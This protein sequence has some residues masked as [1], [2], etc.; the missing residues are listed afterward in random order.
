[1]PNNLIRVKQLD[2]N[3]LSGFVGQSIV[4]TGFLNDYFVSR[5]GDQT[6]SGIKT[7]TNNLQASGT[8]I[9][10][11][12]V[13]NNLQSSGSGIFNAL[14]A[15]N[16]Q[17]GSGIFNA[18]DLNNIDKLSISGVDIAISGR[19]GIGIDS[20]NF[21]LYVRK[22]SAGAVNPD[23]G[24]IAVFEGSGN[25]HITVLASDGQTAGVVLGSPAD[26]FG[27]YLS[28]NHDN[29]E[30]KLATANPDGYIQ[31]L[32]NTETQAV[33]I[34]SVGNVG[35]GMTS[36]S[37]K[38]EVFG[39]I[40]ASGA[41]FTKHLTVNNTGVLLTGQNIFVLQGGTTEGS[42][43]AADTNYIGLAGGDI[44]YSNT[45]VSRRVPILENCVAR[46]A[47]ITLQQAAA[48]ASTSS[49]TGSIVNLT[50]GLTG[51]IS[52]SM[53]TTNNSNFISFSNSDLN[54]PFSAGDN[55]AAFI[56]CPS[57]IANLR[58]LV[59]VYFYN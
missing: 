56:H 30:L 17:V 21:N 7:F 48:G 50:Q 38:L 25:S 11:A 54:V 14:V 24:S 36:P 37:E 5:V 43:A 1:M 59:N 26:N 3:E 32:T 53:S 28:W 22:S 55:A 46:K 9:F 45:P 16:L 35:V 27:S 51:I 39:N 34:T 20:N 6:I 47:S 10:N 44:G 12:L 58:T 8:G 15:N 33:R 4:R 2:Q 52:Q 57:A 40:R 23:G 29:N 19:V 31:F 42:T 41:S 18:L 49:I 13:A